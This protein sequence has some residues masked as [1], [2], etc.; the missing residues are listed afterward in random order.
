MFSETLIKRAGLVWT[1]S[2]FW[3]LPH[4]PSYLSLVTFL[5]KDG[6]SSRQACDHQTKVWKLTNFY[7]SW[8]GW[9]FINL[10]V[11]PSNDFARR[12]TLC[13]EFTAFCSPFPHRLQS[14]L[15]WNLGSFGKLAIRT[16][17]WE[18]VYVSLVFLQ[19][20]SKGR[21]QAEIFHLTAVPLLRLGTWLWNGHSCSQ[22]P[23]SCRNCLLISLPHSHHYKYYCLPSSK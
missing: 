14:C 16:I 15:I 6:F 5:P 22:P 3:I 9:H 1:Q 18:Y 12:S 17:L 19:I 11:Q 10:L 7:S 2:L 13:L 21:G 23:S 8:Q 4:A 20:N